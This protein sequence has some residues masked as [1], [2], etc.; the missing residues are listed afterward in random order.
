MIPSASPPRANRAWLLDRPWRFVAFGFG[1]GLSSI[2]PGTVGTLWAWALALFGQSF[3]PEFTTSDVLIALLCGFAF[4]SW[5]CGRSGAELGVCDH[6]GMVWDEMIAFWLI[7]LVIM[8]A[9]WEIQ[10]LA[11]VVFRFF[12]IVKPG[13]ITWL[14]QYFKKWQGDAVFGKWSNTYRGF[15]V[16]VDDILAAFFTLIVISVFIKLGF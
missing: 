6:A 3:F 14:D 7:L 15:G 10:A 9:S 12:D 13:P 5:A 11:F 2:A 4:G 16:M 8:P 1:S